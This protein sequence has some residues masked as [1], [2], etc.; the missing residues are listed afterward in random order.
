MTSAEKYYWYKEHEQEIEEF[1]EKIFQEWLKK[2]IDKL[3]DIKN[4]GKE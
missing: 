3:A 4:I 1:F 2:Y